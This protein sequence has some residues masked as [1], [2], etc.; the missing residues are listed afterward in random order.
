L[1]EPETA[2]KVGEGAGAEAR[3]AEPAKGHEQITRLERQTARLEA[4]FAVHDPK[5]GQRGKELQSTVTDNE[6]ANRQTAPGVI[7]GSKGQA[8]VEAQQQVIVHAA[9]VGNGQASG[10]VAPMGEGA[11]ANLQAIGLPEA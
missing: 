9:A 1:A 10:P 5:R 7:Q 4:C 3:L 2:E 11:K 6:S 8:V